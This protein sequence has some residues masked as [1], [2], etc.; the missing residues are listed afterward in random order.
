MSEFLRKVVANLSTDFHM[1]QS[2]S[3][4]PVS[5]PSHPNPDP[6][7]VGNSEEQHI[8]VLPSIGDGTNQASAISV[9][10][11]H[12]EFTYLLPGARIYSAGDI[13][14]R[15]AT[16]NIIQQLQ[17]LLDRTEVVIGNEMRFHLIAQAQNNFI[18]PV[19][20]L[21]GL[22]EGPLWLLVL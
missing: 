4:Q 9:S 6:D 13:R 14:N 11:K 8:R 16:H 15:I 19:L 17:Q 20:N 18:L 2:C 3:H 1:A 22:I 7:A 10:S 5:A 12:E 21:R